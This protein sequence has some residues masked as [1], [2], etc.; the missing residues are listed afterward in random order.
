LNEV[1]KLINVVDRNEISLSFLFGLWFSVTGRL[2][3]VSSLGWCSNRHT[4]VLTDNSHYVVRPASA[5]RT[6][7]SG[8]DRVI[9]MWGREGVM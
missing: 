7:S 1:E 2:Y 3:S 6:G 4:P 9:G 8:D 5:I